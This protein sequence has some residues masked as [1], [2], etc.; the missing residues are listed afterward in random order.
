MS[1]LAEH[2]IVHE[3]YDEA[4]FAN[5]IALV[6]LKESVEYNENAQKI[7]LATIPVPVGTRVQFCGF[8]RMSVSMFFYCENLTS[9][10]IKLM[11]KKQS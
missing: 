7:D 3:N 9:I 4:S 10:I 11:L 1:Y 8:D 6:R 2:A 5:D